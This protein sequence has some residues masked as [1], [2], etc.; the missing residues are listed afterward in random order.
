VINEFRVN[1]IYSLDK[2]IFSDVD[3]IAAENDAIKKESPNIRSLSSEMVK[4]RSTK[5]STSELME[6]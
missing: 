2:Y 3:S 4:T 5:V 6:I 1:G